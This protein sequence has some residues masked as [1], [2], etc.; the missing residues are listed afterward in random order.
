MKNDYRPTVLG[1]LPEIQKMDP[2]AA[3]A[4]V[5]QDLMGAAECLRAIRSDYV[6]GKMSDGEFE[7]IEKEFADR[8][9]Q[10]RQMLQNLRKVAQNQGA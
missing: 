1:P 6:N 8:L 5:E 3:I 4:R 7:K 10:Q 2:R 9:V